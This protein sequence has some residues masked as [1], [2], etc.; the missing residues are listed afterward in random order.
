M[1]RNI[2]WGIILV[3][4]IA[5]SFFLKSQSSS[6]T[7]RIDAE[8]ALE[9]YESLY[10]SNFYASLYSIDEIRSF[11]IIQ[12][13]K[14]IE[15][16]ENEW[17]SPEAV[18]S[19]LTNKEK[20]YLKGKVLI[21]IKSKSSE[22]AD[23]LIMKIGSW[24]VADNQMKFFGKNYGFSDKVLLSTMKA[25]PMAKSILQD[26]NKSGEKA[27]AKMNALEIN[28]IYHRAVNNLSEMPLNDQM[29]IYSQIYARINS[30]TCK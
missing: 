20:S 5:G 11:M 27:I 16:Y 23:R 22:E 3:A 15:M 7:S 2:F 26:E 4:M 28:E 1:L 6:E 24:C 14:T 12:L 8:T 30:V 21:Y 25:L 10:S 29:D 9:R 13:E 19:T 17:I 18:A